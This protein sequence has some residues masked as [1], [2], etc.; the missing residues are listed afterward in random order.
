[1]HLNQNSTAKPFWQSHGVS[2]AL[3][4]AL[5][6][7]GVF[8]GTVPLRAQLALEIEPGAA[9]IWSAELK[10]RRVAVDP[11]RLPRVAIAAEGGH[12]IAG[13]DF[14]S[15]D[16]FFLQRTREETAD[17]PTPPSREGTLR[18]GPVLLAAN[19]RLEGAAWL[20]GSSPYDSNVLAAAWNG[21]SWEPAETVSMHSTGPQLALSAAVLEDGSWLLIWAGFDGSDDDIFWS[22]RDQGTW[23]EP[24][25]LHPNNDVPD[26]LPTVAMSDGGARAAWSF[27]DG[28]DYRVRTARWNGSGWTPE[29]A[30]EGRGPDRARLEVV[31][32]RSF[33][34]FQTVVPEAWHLVEFDD[35]GA[36][37][38]STSDLKYA[39]AP[40]IVID[41]N[42]QALLSWP[43]RREEL[44]P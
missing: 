24:R 29:P 30:L 23:S 17:L 8:S 20:E 44:R 2:R 40:L 5:A 37:S 33:L 13:E 3:A 16:L 25:R 11:P 9:R 42:A 7:F 28:S 6:L 36:R 22:R 15:G 4:A 26:I 32:G 38:L 12:V 34:T 27:F 35:S 1:M 19:E 43:W 21:T 31:E 14:A 41:E 39:E 18:T 10:G